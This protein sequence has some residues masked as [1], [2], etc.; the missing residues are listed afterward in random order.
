MRASAQRLPTGANKTN[1]LL[2]AS[3]AVRFTGVATL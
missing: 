1:L 2:V 3:A